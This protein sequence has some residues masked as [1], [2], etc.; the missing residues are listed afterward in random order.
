MGFNRQATLTTPSSPSLYK[1]DIKADQTLYLGIITDM[2]DQFQDNNR[3]M[4]SSVATRIL[5]TKMSAEL[6]EVLAQCL[7]SH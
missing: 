7:P 3:A 5:S 1:L 2:T 6:S 4:S